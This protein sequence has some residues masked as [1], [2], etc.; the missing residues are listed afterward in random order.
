MVAHTVP[1]TIIIIGASVYTLLKPEW[2]AFAFII[3]ATVL[4]IACAAVLGAS[5]Y[6]LIKLWR[7]G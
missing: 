7:E 3:C 1:I 2:K 4:G 5:I 6:V